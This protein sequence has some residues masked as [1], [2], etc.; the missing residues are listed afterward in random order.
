MNDLYDTLET[1]LFHIKG[2]HSESKAD[3]KRIKVDPTRTIKQV[4]ILSDGPWMKGLRL[5][6][7]NDNDIVNETWFKGDDYN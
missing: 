1:P 4:S 3:V 5:I 7:E 2:V 6:D